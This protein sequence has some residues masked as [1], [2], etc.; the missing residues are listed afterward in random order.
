MA[1]RD[2]F[3]TAR[4]TQTSAFL[5]LPGEIRTLIYRAALVKPTPIDLWPHKFIKDNFEHA[6]LVER[7]RKSTKN[8]A[9][10]ESQ[11]VRD[12]SDLKYVRRELATGILATCKQ[13][14]MEATMLF[15][16]ENSFRFSGDFDWRGLRRFLVSIGPEA[17]S[18]IRSLDVCPPG[19]ALCRTC[20]IM[21][22]NL[23]LHPFCAVVAKN[24]PKTHM[25]KSLPFS[26]QT[27]SAYSKLQHEDNI[28]FICEMFRSEGVLQKLNLVIMDGWSFRQLA[29][30]HGDYPC[31]QISQLYDFQKLT[32]FCKVSVILESGSAMI[33]VHN[34]EFLNNFNIT[35]V[36]QPGSRAVPQR[37]FREGQQLEWGYLADAL[38]VKELTSWAPPATKDLVIESFKIFDEAD[39][40]EA[41]ARGGKAVKSTYYGRRKMERR[42]KGFGGC[43]FV[44]RYGNYCNDC[45]Q[46]LKNPGGTFFT[47][48]YWCIHCKGTSGYT[49]KD[50]IEVR[51]ISREKRVWQQ[52]EEVDED[53]WWQG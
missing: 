3:Q 7:L 12:Q 40:V 2:K 10:I 28:R 53:A 17:R 6:D 30:D 27:S 16:R 21:D 26:K 14:R 44:E 15:W 31:D 25:Q 50:C 22:T 4:I 42:L 1:R 8:T 5:K 36:A 29:Q 33:G 43:R 23:R 39:T 49:S 37:P 18:R 51:K 38:D 13:V 20:E 52:A 24:H 41:P 45:N 46:Q 34:R 11:R 48:K 9:S 47:H 32:Y 35:L 19:W